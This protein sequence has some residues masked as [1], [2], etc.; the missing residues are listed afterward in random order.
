MRIING[1]KYDLTTAHKLATH[2]TEKNGWLI[3]WDLYKS[4]EGE[5]FM[6]REHNGDYVVKLDASETLDSVDG[7]TIYTHLSF[8]H[9]LNNFDWS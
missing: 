4:K 3:T 1:K 7:V 5:L 6:H 9:M 2:E 8:D